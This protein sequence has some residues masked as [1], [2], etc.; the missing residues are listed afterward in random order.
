MVKRKFLKEAGFV[1]S[2]KNK[3][4]PYC[5]STKIHPFSLNC[6][7]ST[8]RPALAHRLRRL[9]FSS[10][11]HLP[12]PL[13]FGP[14]Y[15]SVFGVRKQRPLCRVDAWP[16]PASPA[17]WEAGVVPSWAQPQR[18]RSGIPAQVGRISPLPEALPL[19][20]TRALSCLRLPHVAATAGRR[21]GG[22]SL[23]TGG[24]FAAPDLSLF[25]TPW[26][27]G[28]RRSRPL[29]RAGRETMTQGHVRTSQ[30]F[31]FKAG[32]VNEQRGRGLPPR[33]SP[34][35]VTRAS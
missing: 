26:G 5:P 3:N 30:S 7:V 34:A 19:P 20:L 4:S 16:R 15:A 29:T 31:G 1:F 24:P 8:I 6:W 2:S 28:C 9:G 12:T 17:A 21:A 14:Y 23:E 33:Q 22:L 35:S 18:D 27:Q 32:S 11:Q 25:V 13:L 10:H